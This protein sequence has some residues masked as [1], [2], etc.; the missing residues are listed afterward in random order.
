MI[1]EKL[2]HQ[3]GR[4]KL[5]LN[6]ESEVFD[7]WITQQFPRHFFQKVSSIAF[8]FTINIDDELLPL[9][10]I[11]HAAK[12]QPAKGALNCATL[13]VKNFGFK[14]NVYDDAGL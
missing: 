1:L 2:Q 4:T 11:N 6:R 10:N 14:C 5:V 12:A 8:E 7:Y 3:C 9:T 13:R